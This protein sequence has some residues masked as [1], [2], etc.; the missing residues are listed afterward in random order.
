M[1]ENRPLES[2]E[3]RSQKPPSPPIPRAGSRNSLIVCIGNSKPPSIHR[4][5]P[6]PPLAHLI[7]SAASDAGDLRDVSTAQKL[8][9]VDGLF[10]TIISRVSRR[11]RHWRINAILCRQRSCCWH[12]K[13][14]ARCQPDIPAIASVLICVV[15][16]QWSGA[17]SLPV[18][19]ADD[20]VEPGIL[21]GCSPA[22]RRLDGVGHQFT[23]CCARLSGGQSL[24]IIAGRRP[25]DEITARN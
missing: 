4:S 20:P 19:A 6:D 7:F 13:A 23:A 14:A 12:Y 5:P 18:G 17:L 15:G 11:Y 1:C 21:D 24:N 9:A 2:T 10:F 16:A 3:S 22:R 25:P 8:S